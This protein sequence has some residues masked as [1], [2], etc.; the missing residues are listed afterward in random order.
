MNFKFVFKGLKTQ[1][2]I[3]VK[4]RYQIKVRIILFNYNKN[5]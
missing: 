5:L 2:F 4:R 1:N 3:K